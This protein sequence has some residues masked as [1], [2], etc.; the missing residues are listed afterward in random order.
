MYVLCQLFREYRKVIIIQ[1]IAVTVSSCTTG[2]S[3]LMASSLSETTSIG[4][5]CKNYSSVN[6][7]RE[8]LIDNSNESESLVSKRKTKSV[9]ATVRELVRGPQRLWSVLLFSSIAAIGSAVTGMTLGYSSPA[10]TSINTSFHGYPARVE[11]WNQWANSVF[12]VSYIYSCCL[13]CVFLGC[14]TYRASAMSGPFLVVY[15]Q[16]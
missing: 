5:C 14:F 2:K 4:V 12:G 8:S 7:S 6:T 11:V 16:Y 1:E 10:S 13:L 15:L 3:A 9:F